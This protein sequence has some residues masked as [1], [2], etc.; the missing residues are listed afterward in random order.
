MVEHDA[1]FLP[2]LVLP[3]GRDERCAERLRPMSFAAGKSVRE[4]TELD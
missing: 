1:R 2:A 4:F 3:C